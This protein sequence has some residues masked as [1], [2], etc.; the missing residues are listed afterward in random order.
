MNVLVSKEVWNLILT[1]VGDR[2]KTLKWHL[3]CTCASHISASLSRQMWKTGHVEGPWA[4]GIKEAA[5]LINRAQHST[6]HPSPI[7]QIFSTTGPRT[8]K[9]NVWAHRL[10]ERRNI[11]V[12]EE[13]SDPEEDE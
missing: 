6:T 2:T 1:V 13:I 11:V 12:Y 8:L 9:T 4:L 7:D 5:H 3:E 10:R